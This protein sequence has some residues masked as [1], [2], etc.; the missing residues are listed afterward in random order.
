LSFIAAQPCDPLLIRLTAAEI[1]ALPDLVRALTDARPI[2]IASERAPRLRDVDLKLAVSNKGIV[3]INLGGGL[4]AARAAIFRSCSA[5]HPRTRRARDFSADV[6]ARFDAGSNRWSAGLKS[7]FTCLDLVEA[8]ALAQAATGLDLKGAGAAVRQGD[9]A[10]LSLDI[11]VPPSASLRDLMRVSG[12]LDFVGDVAIDLD[13]MMLRAGAGLL[14]LEGTLK[15]GVLMGG[16]VELRNGVVSGLLSSKDPA[17]G[18]P[19]H[20]NHRFARKW[21]D[22]V[23]IAFRGNL[24]GKTLDA[25]VTVR[26]TDWRFVRRDPVCFDPA[27]KDKT[28]H[29]P[30]WVQLVTICIPLS[31]PSACGRPTWRQLEQREY[32]CR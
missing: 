27:R 22:Q 5:V 4:T 13:D 10:T 16:R 6:T 9:I 2:R 21:A 15:R 32:A 8:Q 18:N 3:S 24:G 17:L 23:S 19:R 29:F 26:S 12:T 28:D 1:A 11:T 20:A 31:T 25:D 7:V 30:A 14:G